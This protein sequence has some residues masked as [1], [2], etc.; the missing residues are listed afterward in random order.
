MSVFEYQVTRSSRRKTLSVV[1]RHA[2]VKVLVP[3]FVSDAQIN[4]FVNERAQWIADKLAIQREYVA[5]KQQYVKRF[6]EG[7]AFL[8]FGEPVQ[9]HVVSAARSWVDVHGTH[10]VVAVSDKVIGQ[11]RIDTIKRLLSNWYKKQLNQYVTAKMRGY[12]QLMGVSYQAL[13]VRSYKRRWGSCSSQGVVSFNL[14]LAMAPKTVID[15]VIVHELCHRVHMNHS[16]DFWALVARYYPDYALAK[17]WLKDH[18][19]LLQL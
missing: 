14:L 6:V 8:L 19:E 5:Q 12:A 2:E 15:Y 13:K 17:T 11:K 7:E 16:A 10:L 9:L 3:S 4:D 18:S 1:I